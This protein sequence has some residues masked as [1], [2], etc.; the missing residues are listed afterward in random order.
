MFPCP[1]V[2]NHPTTIKLTTDFKLKKSIDKYSSRLT[3]VAELNTLRGSHLPSL[4]I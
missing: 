1:N 2:D 4:D 3:N